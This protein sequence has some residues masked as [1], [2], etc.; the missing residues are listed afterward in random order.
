MEVHGVFYVLLKATI[1][2]K[3]AHWKDRQDAQLGADAAADWNLTEQLDVR[4]PRWT[5]A[6]YRRILPSLDAAGG[7][8]WVTGCS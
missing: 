4:C 7:E 2:K 3:C 5:G 6:L 1:S 8:E